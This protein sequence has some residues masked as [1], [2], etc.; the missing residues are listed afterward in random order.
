MQSLIVHPAVTE[1]IKQAG[2]IYHTA[3]AVDLGAA[4][5]SIVGEEFIKATLVSSLFLLNFSLIYGNM[6]FL[7]KNITGERAGCRT[8]MN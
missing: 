7:R 3:F 8:M 5:H 1:D 4:G 2:S 6:I